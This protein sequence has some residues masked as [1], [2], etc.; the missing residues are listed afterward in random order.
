MRL[1]SCYRLTFKFECSAELDWFPPLCQTTTGRALAGFGT[2]GEG[3][4]LFFAVVSTPGNFSLSLSI[5]CLFLLVVC[6]WP[7]RYFPP[8]A[9]KIGNLVLWSGHLV[10][11][12]NGLMEYADVAVSVG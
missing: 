11:S 8:V 9:T 2:A 6:P 3:K 1:Q 10:T 4:D 5:L 12:M 7:I